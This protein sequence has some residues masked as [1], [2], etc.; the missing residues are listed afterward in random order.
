MKVS[1]FIEKFVSHNTLIRLWYRN[2]DDNNH[3]YE[4]NGEDKPMME[5][6]IL[7]TIFADK[8]VVYVTDIL[9]PNSPYIEAVN[10]VIKY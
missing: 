7:K 3:L 8:E 10:L 1:E 2:E 5:H 4:V 6:Q 9:Y